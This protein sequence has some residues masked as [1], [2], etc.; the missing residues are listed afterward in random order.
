LEG[1]GHENL[2]FFVPKWQL[3]GH[4][5]FLILRGGGAV[6]SVFIS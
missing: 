5:K 2:D 4:N 6:Q 1:V 3:T